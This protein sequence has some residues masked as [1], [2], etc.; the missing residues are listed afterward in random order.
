RG[1]H[2][3][4]GYLLDPE[5]NRANKI[6][7]GATLWHRTGDAARRDRQ[8]RLWLMGRVG[9][10]VRRAGATWWGQ[11]AELRALR[12]PGVRHA[13]YLGAPDVELGQR[14]VLCVECHAEPR[15]IEPLIRAALAPMPVDEL[16]VLDIPRDPRHHSKTDWGA[17]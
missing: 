7:D 9:R 13:A 2:V 1:A 10:R 14:A 6:E 4:G 12:V 17:L 3:L 15:T 16:H 8:G 11:P 5:A